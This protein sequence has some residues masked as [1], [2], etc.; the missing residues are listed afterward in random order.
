LRRLRFSVAFPFPDRALRAQLWR[1][2]L[3][4][5]APVDRLDFDKLARLDV[6]GG[7]IR[8]IVLDAAFSAA[9]R[10]EP[11]RTDDVLEAA[12]RECAKIEKQLAPSEIGDWI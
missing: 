10:D 9:E 7:T 1:R 12:Q 11:I 8:N 5:A 3:P 2:A 4:A 6:T